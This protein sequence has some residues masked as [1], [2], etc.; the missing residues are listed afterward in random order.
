MTA[1]EIIARRLHAAGC[2]HAFGMPG[3]EVLA[4]LDALTRA[5]IAFHL[6]RHENAAGYMA[7][8]TWHA[9]G[10]PGILLATLGPGIL[11]AVNVA[12]NAL[13]ERVPLVLISG[14]VDEAEAM[15][16]TH[17]VLDHT[18]VF[19]PVTKAA[20]R[21][22]AGAAAETVDKALEIALSGRPG[23]VLLD[24]P[25][26]VATAEEA[27]DGIALRGPV[28]PGAPAPGAA[29]EEAR[30]MFRAARR[31]V[32]VAGLDVLNEPGGAEAVRRFVE[33]HGVP[34]LTTYKAK[35]VLPED[36]PLALGGHG[37]SPKADAIVLPLLEAADLV[38]AAG[39][40]PIEMRAGWRDP[41]EPAKAVEFAH[42]P[43]THGMHYARLSW[44]S[45]VAAGLAALE[46]GAEPKTGWPDD[47]PARREGGIE[48]RAG[49]G[50][51]HRRSPR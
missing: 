33:R 31:P 21:V 20:L 22:P 49:A 15:R 24:L 7:E 45:S 36:H 26:G 30:A 51:R 13:Q 40:D 34:L 14:A 29:L 28:L 46:E 18:Q 47:A 32:M 2:R 19:A 9:T 4:M 10:A 35:G 39:Y 12:A 25:I 42:A 38:I 44:V 41:W 17:Q 50:G 23:P 11:N 6:A 3:G 48:R 37:L 1:A 43:N 8:G 5:G 27:G 16:Y